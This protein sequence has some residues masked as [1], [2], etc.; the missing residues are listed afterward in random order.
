MSFLDF[1]LIG[2][3]LNL[4]VMSLFIGNKNKMC[5]E[6]NILRNRLRSDRLMSDSEFSE[7]NKAILFS[8]V[9]WPIEV[10]SLLLIVLSLPR[11]RK[12]SGIK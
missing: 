10:L 8:S 2:F 7:S 9:V 11:L 4:A 3:A 6:F 12:E 5:R 1:Y